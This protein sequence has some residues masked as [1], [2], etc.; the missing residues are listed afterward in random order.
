MQM[1]HRLQLNQP[2]V[3]DSE[4]IDNVCAENEKDSVHMVGK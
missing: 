2:I 4:L 3:L 1:Q